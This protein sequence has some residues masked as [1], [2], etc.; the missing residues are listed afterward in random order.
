MVEEAERK[1]DRS[2][3][4]ISHI[5]FSE[6]WARENGRLVYPHPARHNLG[7][8]NAV[9]RNVRSRSQEKARIFNPVRAAGDPCRLLADAGLRRRRERIRRPGHESD[10]GRRKVVDSL[11]PVVHSANRRS[12]RSAN[13]GF[14][15]TPIH[16][17][18][19]SR[20]AISVGTGAC[21]R[22]EHHVAGAA[23]NLHASPGQSERHDCRMVVHAAARPLTGLGGTS[24]VSAQSTPV[25]TPEPRRRRSSNSGSWTAGTRSHATWS[26]GH[27]P[28]PG[29]RSV[30]AR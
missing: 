4:A 17:R 30:C 29:G 13:S 5:G 27:E 1:L 10:R 8:N 19:R 26:A 28:I 6:N 21:I 18:L 23:R 7:E 16:F 3:N 12:I 22:I 2:K 15:S 24:H 20:A 11:L 14:N 25:R 9:R